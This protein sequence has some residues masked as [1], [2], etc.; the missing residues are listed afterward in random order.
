MFF[1]KSIIMKI[2]PGHCYHIYNRGINSKKIFFTDTDFSHFLYK[3]NYYPGLSLKTFAYCLMS[4]HFHF[5]VKILPLKKLF[6]T[7]KK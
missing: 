2:E 3:Y 4:N 6:Q 7:T 5:L 1:L